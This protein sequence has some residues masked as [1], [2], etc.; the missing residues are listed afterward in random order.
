MRNEH[1]YEPIDK[2]VPECC[3]RPAPDDP[4]CSDCCYDVWKEELK[5]VNKRYAQEKEAA[6][7][8]QRQIDFIADRR[9]RYKRWQDEM[10]LAEELFRDLCMQLDIIVTQS[11]KIWFNSCKANDAVKVLF[12]MIHDFFIEVD[13]LKC[14]YDEIWNCIISNP[15]PSLQE[16]KG[17][18]A[19]LKYYAEK[20]ET[21]IKTRDE[22]V[23]L[24]VAAVKFAQVMRNN[25]NTADCPGDDYDPCHDEPTCEVPV[26]G[27]Y[28]YGFKSV[29]CEWQRSF[30]CDV[31]CGNG[32]NGG[33]GE[34]SYPD[35]ANSYGPGQP[36][37]PPLPPADPCDEDCELIP[38]F[39]LPVCNDQ[40]KECV[41]TWVADDTETL[42][43]L[44]DDIIR[45]N[46]RKEGSLACK[47]T[48]TKAIEEADPKLRCK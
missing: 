36:T 16:D 40:Y 12:C 4:T 8:L 46:K 33:N 14:R 2:D 3:K 29:I 22:L 41:D 34:T 38:Q 10:L 39:S 42:V 21:V 44:R 5:N 37:P 35:T 25:L 1:Y 27:S 47:Q 15:D 31:Q 45:L 7:S 43:R 24:M 26:E 23:R 13:Y 28:A 18:R 19:C 11:H 30:Q 9:S 32:D 20:L 6:E 48:L 17:I